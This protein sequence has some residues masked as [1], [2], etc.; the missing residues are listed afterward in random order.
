MKHD[1]KFELVQQTPDQRNSSINWKKSA[2]FEQTS[3]K[4]EESPV[5]ADTNR[6]EP[7]NT[8]MGQPTEEVS[9]EDTPT[10]EGEADQQEPSPPMMEPSEDPDLPRHARANRGKSRYDREG[11]WAT[12]AVANKAIPST[13]DTHTDITAMAAS[14]DPDTMYFHQ[15]MQQPDREKFIE[16]AQKEIASH[17]ARNWEVVHKS[18]VPQGVQIL[19]A[20]WSMK[21][22]RRIKTR[23]VYKWKARLNIDG[24]KQKKGINYWETFAPVATW[25][26]IRTI[27]LMALQQGWKTKQI[28]FVLAYTQAD[29]ECDMYMRIPRG[30]EVE[31]EDQD[32]V[33]KLKKNLFGQKQAGRV[34]NQHL[35]G[36][37]KEIGFRQ[38][39]VDECVFYRGNSIYVLYTD[40]SILTGPNESELDQIIEDM[41]S[42][43]LELTVEGDVTDFLGVHIERKSDG[44]IIMSQ[45]HLI[46]Q[47][48]TMLRLDGENTT[49]KDIPMASSRLLSRHNDSPPFDGHFDYRSVIGKLNYLEKSTRPDISYAVHQCARFAASPRKE[50]GE[51]VKWLGRYLKGT[52]DK[53]II[54]KPDEQDFECFVDADFSGNWDADIADNDPDTARSR[55]G[56]IVKF[57]GCPILWAS[58]LQTEV[59]L[60]ST[61]AEYV[62]LSQSMRE[63]LPLIA[64][65]QEMNCLLYTSPSPRDGATSRMPSS[66]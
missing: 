11:I 19:P 30:F 35:V 60:S 21:R 66:A 31:G 25:A 34:W 62:A 50:H 22:K 55:T 17:S 51:A 13:S 41:K 2:G 59:A 56:Y 42:T 8:P 47:I 63:V 64:L 44:S 14:A 7:T 10:R 24:S 27:I 37:L 4:E 52:R 48:L 32:Y 40:D 43:G 61:E 1:T 3:R 46:D 5:H 38:S 12:I 45:P 26:S 6:E 36:K 15:A 54:M 49:T 18:T 39:S 16:A 57:N 29:V 28:D 9:Q 33:I 58:K 65:T 20:V 23:E 53:G